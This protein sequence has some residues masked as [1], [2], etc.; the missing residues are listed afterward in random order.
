[1]WT[2]NLCGGRRK[3][4]PEKEKGGLDCPDTRSKEKGATYHGKKKKQSRAD[5]RPPR[6]KKKKKLPYIHEGRKALHP[7]K[8]FR[9]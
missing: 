4:Q 8:A 1:M 7:Q 6:K 3:R 9:I 2:R 5:A